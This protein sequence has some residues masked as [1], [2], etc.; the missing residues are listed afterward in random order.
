MGFHLHIG[1]K[2]QEKDAVKANANSNATTSSTLDSQTHSH[3]IP[4]ST[5]NPIYQP[6]LA[7]LTP[8]EGEE[9]FYYPLDLDENTFN[10][11]KSLPP[12][13]FHDPPQQSVNFE[14]T[15]MSHSN[16]APTVK[17]EFDPL[18]EAPPSK[19]YGQGYS[20]FNPVPTVQHYKEEHAK[21]EEESKHYAEVVAARQREADER[22]RTR[23]DQKQAE[24][25]H[26]KT[27]GEGGVSEGRGGEK[28]EGVEGNVLK[29]T[30]DK[31]DK[32]VAN[33]GTS[34]KARMMDQMNA[35]QREY[36]V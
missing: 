31:T 15:T 20:A 18:P 24:D 16:G 13:P 26:V 19:V 22:E 27:V 7:Q 11:D 25:A 32:P 28:V 36:R 12:T 21:H 4:P 3:L 2:D 14:R 1:K 17:T 30:K 34:E 29:N 8:H 33:S 6:H 9:P 5:S 23:H 10:T 35:N